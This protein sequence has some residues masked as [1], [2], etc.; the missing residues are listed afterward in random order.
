MSETIDAVVERVSEG[1]NLL[2]SLALIE[3]GTWQISQEVFRD[4]QNGARVEGVTTANLGIYRIVN[5]EVVF[6]LLGREGNLF[7]DERFRKDTYK[8]ILSND[9]F[10]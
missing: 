5:G 8:G 1:G 9:L 6:D 10:I 4:W 3:P 7:V 2:A